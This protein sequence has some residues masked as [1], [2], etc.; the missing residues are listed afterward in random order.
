MTTTEKAAP[1]IGQ[2]VPA[3]GST[4]AGSTSGTQLWVGRALSTLAILFLLFDAL[5]KVFRAQPVVEGTVQ[6]GYPES[7]IVGIGLVL[8]AC[9]VI[10]LIP[11]TAVLGAILLTGFLGG[12]VATHVRLLNPL[13]SHTLFPVYVAVFVWLG[14]ALRDAELRR[15]LLGG[16][17]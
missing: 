13:F 5:T 7:T 4:A 17:G 8:L 11:R 10:H 15:V 16:R 1:V 6:L 2:A 14:L 12:A 3:H 9:I